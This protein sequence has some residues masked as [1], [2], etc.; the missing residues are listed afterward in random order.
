MIKDFK[1]YYLDFMELLHKKYSNPNQTDLSIGYDQEMAI[2]EKVVNAYLG[3]IQDSKWNY[4]EVL[5]WEFLRIA[6]GLCPTSVESNLNYKYDFGFDS[7]FKEIYDEDLD[8]KLYLL[9]MVIQE[10]QPIDIT[11]AL[12]YVAECLLTKANWSKLYGVVTAIS[13]YNN[14]ICIP[15]LDKI[16]TALS[17]KDENSDLIYSSVGILTDIAS[18]DSFN[19]IKN[20]INNSNE[21]LRSEI[22]NTIRYYI[23]QKWVNAEHNWIKS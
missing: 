8:V 12:C 15:L 22:E 14:P 11:K 3:L 21:L 18:Y 2:Y 17:N 13:N 4:E 6:E 19:V 5:S 23:N 9:L 20:H 10:K 7:H 16:L 1:S